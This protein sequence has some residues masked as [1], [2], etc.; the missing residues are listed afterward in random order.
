MARSTAAPARLSVDDWVAAAL[1]LLADEGLSGV[2]VDRLCQR[3]GV[4]KGSFYWHFS[5]LRSLLE[6]VAERWGTAR[7]ARRARFEELAAVEPHERLRLMTAELADQK[8]WSLERAVR[9]W[10]RTDERV[11][12]RVASSD[13]WVY[14]A[15]RRAFADLGFD[16]EQAELRAKTLFYAG[17][18]YIYVGDQGSRGGR[19]QREGLLDILTS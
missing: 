3:L 13:R 6:A 19:R 17:V 4:T 11:R 9:E 16:A 15:M 1:E 12:E 18:G 14:Q 7:D 5:D 8:E 2:K 10:A